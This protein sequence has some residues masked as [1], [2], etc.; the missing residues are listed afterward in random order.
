MP[1]LA[2]SQ[3]ERE[4][5]LAG[6]HV[7]ILAVAEP[8]RGP[9]A[10]PVWYVYEPG[11][12]VR[13]VTGGASKKLP[14][15]RSAGRATLCAQEETPPYRYV[16]VEGPIAIG[17][18]DQERDVRDTALRYL[19]PQMGEVYLRATAAENAAAVLVTLRPERWMTADF[20]K[21]RP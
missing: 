9:F 4:A 8:G 17:P 21:W 16:T 18:P 6:T 20:H 7:A 12:D 11:R 13:V 14:L 3:A 10:V 5:F 2:M 19:G 15:L 1:S